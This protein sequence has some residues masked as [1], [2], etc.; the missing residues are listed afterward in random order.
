MLYYTS[1]G[2]SYYKVS[3]TPIKQLGD[4]WAALNIFLSLSVTQLKAMM[5]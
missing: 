1:K 4:M 5:Y 2:F 3:L